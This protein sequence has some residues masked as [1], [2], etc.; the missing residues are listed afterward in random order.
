MCEKRLKGGGEA[1]NWLTKTICLG[2]DW[3]VAEIDFMRTMVDKALW[4]KLNFNYILCAWI[5]LIY[6]SYLQMFVIE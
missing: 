2:I 4:F 3:K 5:A 1:G 6:S